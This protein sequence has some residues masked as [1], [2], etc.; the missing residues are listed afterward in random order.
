MASPIIWFGSKAKNLKAALQMAS[1]ATLYSGSV[2]PSSSATDGN[3]GDVYISTSTFKIY[4]K[5]DNGS[6]TNWALAGTL[7]L[8]AFGSSPNANGASVSGTTLT[9]Q[10]A[11]VSFPGAV[12][13]GTQSFAGNKTFTGSILADGGLD[14]TST[15]GTDVLSIGVTN[16]DTINIGHSGATVNI[17][18]TTLYEDVTNLQVTD[19]LITVNKGGAAA[20]GTGTGIELEENSS[21]TGYVKTSGDRNSWLMKAPNTAGDVTLTPGA[22]GITLNQSSHDAVTLA[23]IGSTPNAN[24]ASLSSQQLTLQPANGSFGGVVSAT[25]QTFAGDKTFTGFVATTSLQASGQSFVVG[26][27]DT[28]QMYVKGNSTQN[29]DIFQVLK[30]D[31]TGLLQVANS[32]TVTVGNLIDSGLTANTGLIANASKQ[33]TSVALTDGQI[34]IG[35]NSGA[36]AAG[37]IT[38]GSGIS[39]INGTNSITIAS[40]V[41]FSAG[42]IA[43]TSFSL[44]NNQGSPANVTGFAF[45]NG[46]VRS[47]DALVSIY[48]DATTDLF[49]SYKLHG[50][51]KGSSWEMSQ[52]AVGDDSQVVFTITNAGQIQYT[53]GNYTGFSSGTIKFRAITTSV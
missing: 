45:A 10:P 9:L 23:A 49:E 47:F 44:A 14:V 48:I 42:D 40:T 25:T 52:T 3:A 33:L 7:S 15:G 50:I 24:G 22:G 34:I 1:F 35:R 36:P 4:T 31:N 37:N 17:I 53:S 16:A 26:S 21:I 41:P 27:A 6:S 28:V 2:D 19:K 51:Q 20:S 32:G 13:T 5:Q 12:S 46:T 30:S 43:E 8:G 38:A 18:G 29:T 39:V 11:S